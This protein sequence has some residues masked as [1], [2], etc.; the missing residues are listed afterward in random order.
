MLIAKSGFYKAIWVWFKAE[1]E[2]DTT[3]TLKF[4]KGDVTEELP[5]TFRV[6]DASTLVINSVDNGGESDENSKSIR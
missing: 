6:H 3:F 2:G 1:Q 5:V 4:T